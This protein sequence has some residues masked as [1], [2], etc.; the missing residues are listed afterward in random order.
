MVNLFVCLSLGL[1]LILLAGFVAF[2]RLVKV[3]YGTHNQD[4]L[5]DHKPDG[6]LWRPPGRSHFYRMN[7]SGSLCLFLW[8]FRTPPWV[9]QDQVA[10]RHLRQFRVCILV[11]NMGYVLMW[12]WSLGHPELLRWLNKRAV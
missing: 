8:L 9:K 4:W 3:Q 1:I 7:W 12:V 11:W 2:D 5:T 6:L 10:G